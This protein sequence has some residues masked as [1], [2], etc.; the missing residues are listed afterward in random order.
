MANK[1][2]ANVVVTWLPLDAGDPIANTYSG[3]EDVHQLSGATVL[4]FA[5]GTGCVIVPHTQRIMDLEV[6]PSA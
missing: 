3:V 4:H 2:R 6:T 5:K 1:A